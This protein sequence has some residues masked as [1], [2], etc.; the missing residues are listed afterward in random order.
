MSRVYLD[1]AATAPT[2]PALLSLFVSAAAERFGN[3]SSLHIEGRQARAALAEARIKTAAALGCRDSE[4]FFTSGGT[5][6]NGIALLSLLTRL[7]KGN[8]VIS[9]FE[10]PSVHEQAQTLESF[11]FT[12]REVGGHAGFV[13]PEEIRDAVDEDTR[14]VC[15]MLVNNET[16]AIQPVAEIGRLLSSRSGRGGPAPHFHVDGVQA[17]GKIP[18]SFDALNADSFSVSGHKIGAPRGAGLLV[19]R[20]EIL[21]IARGG[22]QERG[23]RPGTE[24]LPG[25]LALAEAVS[26]AARTVADRF[27]H[28]EKLKTLLLRGLSSGDPEG[29]IRVLPAQP[30]PAPDASASIHSGS[31]A[32]QGRF[33]PFIVSITVPPLP[34]ETIVRIMDDAG[35]A[36]SAGSACSSN[37]R[38]GRERALVGSG[39]DPSLASS[40]VRISTGPSTSE[41][42]IIAFCESFV[43]L[44]LPLAGKTGGRSR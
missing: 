3:P 9:R 14:M 32:K 5:E 13:D 26:N 10:H 18:V 42:E 33:S 19:L 34:S 36:I 1:W 38:H 17:V 11:G 40:A 35:F 6:A 21:P 24:N 41:E 37:K 23:F 31:A 20:R 7:R 28:A 2:D 4:V 8:I 29:R 22:G 39:I 43:R 12:L 16:G 27:A 25:I 44:V 15:V 30:V